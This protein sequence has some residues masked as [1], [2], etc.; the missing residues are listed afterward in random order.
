MRP[1][2]LFVD[3]TER[4]ETLR[5]WSGVA[6]LLY[7]E[8]GGCRD[9]PPKGLKRKLNLERRSGAASLT[10]APEAGGS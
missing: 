2:P 6:A 4:D 3:A 5:A 9:E 1:C 8:M 10:E 7:I